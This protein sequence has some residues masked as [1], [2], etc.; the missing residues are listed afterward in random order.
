MK[1]FSWISRA[2]RFPKKIRRFS[3][4]CTVLDKRHCEEPETMKMVLEIG[5]PSE[6]WHALKTLADE[7]EDDAYDRAKQNSRPWRQ[8]LTRLY[9]S[10]LRA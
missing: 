5:S 4:L 6:A 10:I 2:G 9:P 3:C 1:G 8:G 7:T